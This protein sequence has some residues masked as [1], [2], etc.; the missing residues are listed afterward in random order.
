MVTLTICIAGCNENN[1][2]EQTVSE[3]NTNTATLSWQPPIDNTDGSTLTNLAGYKIYYGQSADNLSNVITL[4]NPGITSYMIENL[5][6]GSKYYFAI[7]AYDSDG[8]E[9][10]YSEVVSKDIPA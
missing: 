6:Y 9:S 7:T 5:S 4:D 3:N 1:N 10:N 8:L 2:S